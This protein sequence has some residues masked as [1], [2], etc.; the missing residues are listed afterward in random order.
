MTSLVFNIICASTEALQQFIFAAGNKVSI[1]KYK[2]AFALGW[3]F[4]F[5]TLLIK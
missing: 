4:A 5:S 1:Y 2:Q 3:M